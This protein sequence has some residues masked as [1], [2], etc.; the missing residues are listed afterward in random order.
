MYVECQSLGWG[1]KETKWLPIK[2]VATV[3]LNLVVVASGISKSGKR[4]KKGKK[5]KTTHYLFQTAA[6][7][8]YRLSIT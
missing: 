8:I 4:W 6:I 2:Y 5:K 3:H 1:S 7:L